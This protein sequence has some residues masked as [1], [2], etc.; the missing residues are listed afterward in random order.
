MKF[1]AAYTLL[2]PI[3]A[4]AEYPSELAW[5]TTGCDS[6]AFCGTL[7]FC[8]SGSSSYGYRRPGDS[9]PCGDN[10]GPLIR[11]QPGNKYK[12][13]LHN[14]VSDA[15]LKT[16]IHTHGLHVVGDGDGDDVTRFVEGGSC[17][18]YTWDIATDHPG[19]TYWYHPHYHTLTNDQTSGGAFGMLIIEDNYNQLNAWAHPEN[20]KLLQISNTG[21]VLGNGSDSEGEFTSS[22]WT[23]KQ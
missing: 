7:E 11:M 2:L 5:T 22:V 10:P 12:L 14:T 3:F 19:G 23:P 4:R 8:K 6:G 18:D 20:E 16:N 1:A 17:L 15:S 9:A 21:S 13:T